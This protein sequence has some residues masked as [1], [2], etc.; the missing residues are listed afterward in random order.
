MDLWTAE[1]WGVAI[2][3]QGSEQLL[4]IQLPFLLIGSHPLCEVQIA[5]TR[6]P[7][8]AYAAFCFAD[9][10]EVWP[11]A[12]IAFPVWGSINASTELLVGGRRLRFRHASLDGKSPPDGDVP[13][14]WPSIHSP[15]L[16]QISIRWEGERRLKRLTRRVTIYGDEH[17][18]TLRLHDQGLARCDQAMIAAEEKLYLVNLNPEHAD[19]PPVRQLGESPIQVG[20]TALALSRETAKAAEL[21]DSSA[22][23][24]LR[25]VATVTQNERPSA[26]ADAAPTSE[27]RSMAIAEVLG[28]AKMANPEALTS[29]VTDR[30]VHIDQAKLAR[31][32]VF[33]TLLYSAGFVGTAAALAWIF[34]ALLLP[35]LAEMRRTDLN[36]QA[37]PHS[38]MLGN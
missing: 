7:A 8:V 2:E 18:S 33:R 1:P 38:V 37:A 29:Q 11:V 16:P 35:T 21:D 15:E 13:N 19:H 4:Q 34:L 36:E 31:K 28:S 6:V 25:Q 26:I 20:Q 32:R 5:G 17:P 10:V 3:S 27:A 9:A 14:E 24:L 30:L 22:N 12:P 23:N